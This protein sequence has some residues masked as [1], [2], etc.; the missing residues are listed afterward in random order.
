MRIKEV[1]PCKLFRTEPGKWSVLNTC[2]LLLLFLL[3]MD[4]FSTN[5]LPVLFSRRGIA[6]ISGLWLYRLMKL[7]SSSAGSFLQGEP[8]NMGSSR[9]RLAIQDSCHPM[10]NQGRV[11]T[12]LPGRLIARDAF[13]FIQ[14]RPVRLSKESGLSR[15]FRKELF[16]SLQGYWVTSTRSARSR[17]GL[18]RSCFI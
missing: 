8:S 10:E 17:A 18:L 13:V 7:T 16:S 6:S 3:L 12:L 15:D 2:W 14:E 11:P 1:N 4:A 9:E 5:I